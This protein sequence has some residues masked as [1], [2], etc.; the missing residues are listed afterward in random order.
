MNAQQ[1]VLGL[2]KLRV[3]KVC[4]HL[5][6]ADAMGGDGGSNR[7]ESLISKLRAK[8]HDIRNVRGRGYILMSDDW[9]TK[10]GLSLIHI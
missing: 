10:L 7:L 8:A 4:T 5:A 9:R 6:L 1:R 3:G 2:L